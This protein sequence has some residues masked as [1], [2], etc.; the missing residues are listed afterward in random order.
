MKTNIKFFIIYSTTLLIAI[1]SFQGMLL[2]NF[3]QNPDYIIKDSIH[4]CGDSSGII[5]YSK[6][7]NLNELKKD[8]IADTTI[9]PREVI[10]G[11]PPQGLHIIDSL[12]N[13][14]LPIN[15]DSTAVQAIEKK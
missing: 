3:R 1:F 15:Q 11:E 9:P 4:V 7:V 2:K 10:Q 8:N 6:E 14:I 13:V 12:K 5:S